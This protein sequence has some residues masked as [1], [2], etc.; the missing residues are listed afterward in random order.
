[1][2]IIGSDLCS[3]FCRELKQE[4]LENRTG[5]RMKI[6]H[7]GYLVGNMEKAVRKFETLGY[8]MISGITHDTMRFADICF[9]QMEQ[10]IIELVSPYD[11]RSVVAGMMKK[12]KNMPYHIC[13]E[14]DNFTEELKYLEAN[15]FTRI[16]QPRPAPAIEGRKVCFL[17]GTGI[18]MIEILEEV[19]RG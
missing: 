7:I 10:Y 9:M 8:Q 3:S 12:Y 13:Y 11:K 16:D 15:G 18:G 5:D 1:M 17:L 6:N 14:A 19:K 2:V 4:I